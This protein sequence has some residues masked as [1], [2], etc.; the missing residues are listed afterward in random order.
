MLEICPLTILKKKEAKWEFIYSLLQTPYK[1]SHCGENELLN[2]IFRGLLKPL[3]LKFTKHFAQTIT[4]HVSFDKLI[5]GVEI[6]FEIEKSSNR[7]SLL[8]IRRMIWPSDVVGG[9]KTNDAP[10]IPGQLVPLEII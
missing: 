2:M 9:S 4:N 1:K 5:G 10:V 6:Q 7:L 3:T 8:P